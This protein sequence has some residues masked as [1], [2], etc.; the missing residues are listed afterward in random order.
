MAAQNKDEQIS[1]DTR[2]LPSH[3]QRP[4]T[5]TKFHDDVTKLPKEVR[6][7]LAGGIAGM[8]AKTVVAPLER[9]KILYQVSAEKFTLRRVP[10]VAMNIIRHEGPTALWRGNTATMLRVFPYS[11]IQF[12]V[13]DRCKTYLLREHEQRDQVLVRRRNTDQAIKLFGLSPLESLLSGMIAGAV[14]VLCTYPLDL[15]RAQL[16]LYKTHRHAKNIGFIGVIKHNYGKGGVRGL[17]RGLTP[18][19]LGILPYSGIAFALN[20]QGKRQVQSWRK[21]DLTTIER[22]QCGALSGLFAQTCA[23]PFEVTRRRMQTIGVAPLAG[24]EAATSALGLN[25]GEAGTVRKPRSMLGTMRELYREQ[26]AR[27]FV[28][29]VTMNW[30]RGPVAFSI[31]FTI[32]DVIQGLLETES[33]RA[34]RLPSKLREKKQ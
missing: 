31:S 13:F 19:I 28:K 23:Y 9:I 20:E 15:T 29:G 12:M 30:M 8:V 24:S 27:G 33:E 17:F 11:G 7:I 21:R 16:A 4:T 10:V 18:T 34:L 14:S 32:F 22:M 1:N 3:Q 26:G 2:D 5:R 6:N 25:S